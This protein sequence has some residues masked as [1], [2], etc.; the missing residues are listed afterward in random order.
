MPSPL[1]HCSA[2]LVAMK[3]HAQNPLTA[4]RWPNQHALVEI[5]M[6]ALDVSLHVII[7]TLPSIGI[8]SFKLVVLFLCS[9]K[10]A[11]GRV[12]RGCDTFDILKEDVDP[13]LKKGECVKVDS[14][15]D[16]CLCIADGCNDGNIFDNGSDNV[17]VITLVSIFGSIAAVV[18][19][20]LI[21]CKAKKQ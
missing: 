2:T 13:N 21:W 17:L 7:F 8:S 11:D 10:Y 3:Q 19:G 15:V 14:N 20:V 18:S 4:P 12:T 5:R 6:F 16:V 9:D 1:R